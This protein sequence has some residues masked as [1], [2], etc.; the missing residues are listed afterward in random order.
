LLVE[1]K[2][3]ATNEFL[4]NIDIMNLPDKENPIKQFN[5]TS[6]SLRDIFV[7]NEIEKFSG[8][9]SYYYY[10]GSLTIP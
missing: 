8:Y 5:D 7:S 6:T 10:N 2:P 3:E 9:F 1:K 4:K